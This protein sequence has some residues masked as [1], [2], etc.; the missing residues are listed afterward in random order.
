VRVLVLNSGSSSLKASV[1]ESGSREAERATNEKWEA[2]RA[3]T[4]RRVITSLAGDSAIDVVAHRVVHGGSTF[5]SAVMVD[6]AVVDALGLLVELA[7]LHNATALDVLTEAQR[8]LTAIPHVACFDSAFH[9]TMPE[10][11]WRYPVPASWSDWGV[12]KYGFHGLSVEW[13]VREAARLLDR[14]QSELSVVVAHLGSGC[15]VT[16]VQ[17]GR[18][19][20]TSMGFTPLEGMMMGT[21]SGSIDPGL[22]LYLLRS[23]RLQLDQLDEAL[24]KGSGLLGVSGSSADMR[25][26]RAAAEAGDTNAQLAVEMFVARAAEA[27]AAAMTWV[28]PNALVFTG[29][30]GENDGRTRD[31]ITARLA[32]ARG[33]NGLPVLVVEAREDV[34]MADQAAA[35]LEV[36][37][38]PPGG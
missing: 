30:I 35:L 37:T 31:A 33:D 8:F 20:W 13:S 32:G 19:T 34:V 25:E 10:V 18:S 3:D 21:R 38:D 17:A 36:P 12:R 1:V 9:S 28:T 22:L 5:R 27:I 29:G 4:I 7:P 23:G 11:A 14:P 16:A 2:D 15:S 6:Q 26:L 24:E